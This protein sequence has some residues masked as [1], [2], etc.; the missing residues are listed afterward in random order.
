MTQLYLS[1]IGILLQQLSNIGQPLAGGFVNV[2]V[3]GTVS[4]QQLTYTDSTGA[5][6]N[7]QP[8]VLNSAG[9]MASA[10]GAPVSVWVPA[11]TPHKMVLTDANGN[12]LSG[13]TSMDNLLGINDPTA[14][15]LSLDNPASGFGADLVA[16]AVR[17]YDVIFSVR[18]ANVPTL[19]SGQTLVINIEGGALINDGLGGFFYWSATSTAAD[20][21]GATAIRPFAIP[22][23]SPGR[24][25]R[26]TNTFGLTG[27]FS[28]T[29]SGCTTAPTLT[30]NYFQN[31]GLVIAE[32]GLPVGG[33]LT[34][35][36]TFFKY[37][38][39][40][41]ALRS[42]TLG[43]YSEMFSGEDNTVA[44]ISAFATIENIS[45]S[46]A[47]ALNINNASGLWTNTGTKGVNPFTFTYLL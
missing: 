21:S 43:H 40:P 46:N 17:S 28:L 24:Y 42:Q 32:V 27:N 39:W 7:A 5:T 12:L 18:S 35:N 36:Q 2:L 9:R 15:N 16:N 22:S 11:N 20:D 47:L 10:S 34:S 8:I 38:G 44:G 4:V 45:G 31:G 29:V 37:L 1:P 23:G 41:V 33:P 14:I 26:Q 3:A 13:G 19:Q 25:L 6:A 30:V